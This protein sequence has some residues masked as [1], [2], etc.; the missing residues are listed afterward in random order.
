MLQDRA[1]HQHLSGTLRHV[2]QQEVR[3]TLLL[4]L[5]LC[6]LVD[7]GDLD[8]GA[9]DEASEE[10]WLVNGGVRIHI[11]PGGVVEDSRHKGYHHGD[12]RR[13]DNQGEKNLGKA[14]VLL[15]NTNHAWLKT[16][17]SRDAIRRR[18]QPRAR[19]FA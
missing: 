9:V 13:P 5:T 3:Q 7:L 2:R 6:Q 4:K 8:A 16:F 15:Q 11:R 18:K 10:A 1:L 12:N 17:T 14:I 19:D